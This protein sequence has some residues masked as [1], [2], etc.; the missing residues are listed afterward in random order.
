MC[1]RL[2]AAPNPDEVIWR[3]L[4]LRLWERRWGRAGACGRD[5]E[6]A[7]KL[8]GGGPPP[9]TP[10]LPKPTPRPTPAPPAS[11]LSA[12]ARRFVVTAL[13]FVMALFYVVPVAA[14]QGLLQVCERR[15]GLVERALLALLCA[16][17][18]PPAVA[19]PC[20]H[21]LH[22]ANAP[23][24]APRSPTP[25]QLDRLRRV[26]YLSTLLDLPVVHSL[27][28]GLLPGAAGA[29]RGFAGAG[30]SASSR[31]RGWPALASPTARPPARPPARLPTR[32]PARPPRRPRAAPVC[33]AA[34]GRA[35]PPQPLRGVG[36]QGRR[37]LPGVHT[38]LHF[39]GGWMGGR[40]GGWVGGVSGPPEGSRG[41]ARPAALSFARLARP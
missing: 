2:R 5:R 34:A 23:Q 20:A 27:L 35:V 30:H 29:H 21:I 25:P 4:R 6:A 24:S 1:W 8:C 39:P 16:R 10:A 32:S 38:V 31:T 37:G 19:L 15:Q 33:A 7:R 9:P 3:A 11:S 28:L 26:P 13:L 14:L 18:H 22:L 17:A 12:S 41:D 40:V 36:Q